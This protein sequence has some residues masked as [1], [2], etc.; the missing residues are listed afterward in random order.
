MSGRAPRPSRLQRTAKAVSKFFGKKSNKQPITGL[1]PNGKSVTNPGYT[2]APRNTID[3]KELGL[4]QNTPV[5]RYQLLRSLVSRNANRRNLA[6][7]GLNLMFGKNLEEKDFNNAVDKLGITNTIQKNM[8]LEELKKRYYSK[9][10]SYYRNNTPEAAAVKRYLNLDRNKLRKQQT[11]INLHKVARNP[12]DFFNVLK[13]KTGINKKTFY[14]NL[15]SGKGLSKK[16]LTGLNNGTKKR[17]IR[18][19][20][21][22]QIPSQTIGEPK[23]KEIVDIMVNRLFNLIESTRVP[24]NMSERPPRSEYTSVVPMNGGPPIRSE[25]TSVVPIVGTRRTGP[26]TRELQ[27]APDASQSNF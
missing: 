20:V 3:P 15:I 25:Y 19:A 9:N 7:R 11:I 5:S 8:V 14:N 24:I 18:S 12:D 21:L 2:G 22:S 6:R 1:S 17:I 26:N 27:F 10:I 16:I 13:N 4:T 23:A